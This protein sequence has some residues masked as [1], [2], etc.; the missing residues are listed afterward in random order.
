MYCTYNICCLLYL[1]MFSSSFFSKIDENITNLSSFSPELLV[2][3]ISKCLLLI[4]PS[5]ELPETLPVG[6]AQ[7]YS[8]TT[9]L[10]DACNVSIIN[11]YIF[12]VYV[13]LSN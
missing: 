8:V 4:K 11:D 7:R 6:M 10:A 1:L 5:L 12:S 3:T 9:T 13:F 2:K